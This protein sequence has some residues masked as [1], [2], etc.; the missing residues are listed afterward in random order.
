MFHGKQHVR[1]YVV[2]HFSGCLSSMGWG[3]LMFIHRV[4]ML[5]KEIGT[6]LF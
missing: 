6:F 3:Y 5:L 4:A 1:R 2:E